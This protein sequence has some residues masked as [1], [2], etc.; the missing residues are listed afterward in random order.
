MTT[1]REVYETWFEAQ[2]RQNQIGMEG[3]IGDELKIYVEHYTGKCWEMAKVE[4]VAELPNSASVDLS[5]SA[6]AALHKILKGRRTPACPPRSP[7][8][9]P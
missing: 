7:R 1:F 3:G 6:S 9:S 4:E 8:P 2:K 5:T